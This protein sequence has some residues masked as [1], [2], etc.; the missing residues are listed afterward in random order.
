MLEPTLPKEASGQPCWARRLRLAR[1]RP[2]W[3]QIWAGADPKPRPVA[4][5]LRARWDPSP[6]GGAGD[7][8]VESRG[9]GGT[10]RD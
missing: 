2:C 1:T 6:G 7:Y 4:Q 8:S 10:G 5:H 9:H 3:G